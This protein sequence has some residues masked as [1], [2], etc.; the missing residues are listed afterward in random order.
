MIIVKLGEIFGVGK[1]LINFITELDNG[2]MHCLTLIIPLFT[3]HN[4]V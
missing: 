1:H 3:V 2:V 4:D